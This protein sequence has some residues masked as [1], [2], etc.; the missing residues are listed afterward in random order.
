MTNWQQRRLT[1]GLALL[2]GPMGALAADAIAVGRALFHDP[3]LSLQR[4]QSCATCHSP[5]LA[6]T[7]P[8]SEPARGAV[9]LGADGKSLGRRNAP[10]L[11]Y[12]A[13]TPPFGRDAEGYLGGHFYDGRAATLLDQ[14]EGP[15]LDPTE[16]AMPDIAAVA[17]RLR[18]N[19]QILQALKAL[20]AGLDVGDDAAL[21][22][23]ALQ[24]IVAFER[25][26]AFSTF[27]SKYD[28]FLAGTATMT[29]DETMGREIFFSDLANCHSCHLQDPERRAE[30]EPFTSFRYFNIGAPANPALLAARPGTPVDLG[31]ASNPAA[32]GPQSR[33]K[34]RTPSLRNIA[35]T[36]PYMH[37]GAFAELETAVRFYGKYIVSNDFSEINPE[38]AQPWG[39]AEVPETIDLALLAGGQ[40]IGPIRA[41]QLTAFLRTLTDQRYETLLQPP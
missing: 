12:V 35:V 41:R 23:A 39:P 37:N 21:F 16:M 34:F 9:S 10:T 25:S 6:F 19:A 28:R 20:T 3:N 14:I 24:A 32:T 33:G 30:R 4:T 29:P 13:L 15:L 31:L 40:P 1:W 2:L 8:R 26:E 5:A 18:E 17:A 38:S 36:A 7:D 27:D 22:R 11:T